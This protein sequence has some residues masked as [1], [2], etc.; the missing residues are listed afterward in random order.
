M[1]E[2]GESCFLS[3]YIFGWFWGFCFKFMFFCFVPENTVHYFPF[4]C[5]RIVLTARVWLF[6][7]KKLTYAGHSV[8]SSCLQFSKTIGLFCCRLYANEIKY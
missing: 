4:M 3:I 7:H 2:G 1:G 8:L 6:N 5:I